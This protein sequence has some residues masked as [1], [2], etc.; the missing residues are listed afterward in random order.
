MQEYHS[1]RTER[2]LDE[3]AYCNCSYEGGLKL[4]RRFIFREGTNR[5]FSPLS[6]VASSLKICTGAR[7]YR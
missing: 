6:S 3:V 4:A 7:D 2:A 5:A 1:F